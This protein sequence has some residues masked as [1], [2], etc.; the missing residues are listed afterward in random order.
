MDI[1]VSYYA[2][3]GVDS[4]LPFSVNFGMK[5]FTFDLTS[6]HEQYSDEVNSILQIK[7][8]EGVMLSSRSRGKGGR[9][10]NALMFH[11]GPGKRLS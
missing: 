5:P 6:F 3:I 2:S 4:N 11:H 8:G 10:N 9:R 1:E 7:T